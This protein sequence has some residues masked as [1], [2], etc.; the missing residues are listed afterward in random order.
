MAVPSVTSDF[1]P[2]LRHYHRMES[3]VR[4]FGLIK[5]LSQQFKTILLLHLLGA[6]DSGM[7]GKV[8]SNDT[9]EER[10]AAGSLKCYSG[11]F[12]TLTVKHVMSFF[13]ISNTG[14]NDPVVGS[15]VCDC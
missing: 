15:I 6:N 3:I 10:G 9:G 8:R 2:T 7:K 1:S 13:S 5:Y 12:S 14:N 4:L 11:P